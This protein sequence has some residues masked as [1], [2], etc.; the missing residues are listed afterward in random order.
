M[1]WP[2]IVRKAHYITASVKLS[3]AVVIQ[4]SGGSRVHPWS[5]PTIYIRYYQL[6]VHSDQRYS[7]TLS[8]SPMYYIT[9]WG[10][11]PHSRPLPVP[12]QSNPW[13]L[14]DSNHFERCEKWGG[15]ELALALVSLRYFA[16][17]TT[18]CPKSDRSSGKGS[19]AQLAVALIWSPHPALFTLVQKATGL[20][21]SS[22]P[23]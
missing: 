3:T 13:L 20:V 16:I 15:G 9:D 5:W 18:H 1:R 22:D 21:G 4:W 14:M 11:F 17:L 8:W 19:Q 6:A 23:C 12:R 2:K 10:S 7:H